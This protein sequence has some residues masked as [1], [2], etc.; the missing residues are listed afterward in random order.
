MNNL[1]PCP[2]CG[3][4]MAR[5]EL[6]GLCPDCMLKAGLGS[7]ADDTIAG[8]AA[9]FEPPAVSEIAN[10]F[11]NLDVIELLG[12]GGMGAVYKARQKNLDR[13]V[14]LKI[15]PPDIGSA[16]AF[17]ERF[18]REAK[19][20]AKLSH[21]NIVTIHDFGQAD[22]LFFLLMEFVDGVNLGQLLRAG[23]ISPR[24]A[25]AI[26]PQICDALQYAHDHGIVHR[27]IKPENILLD[28]QG[29]VKVADFGLAKLIGQADFTAQDGTSS[30]IG[31][32]QSAISNAVMGTP[33]YM[34][35]EQ[36]AHPSDVD[37][38]ADIYSLGVVFYQML[39]GELPK[40]DFAPPS[41]KV[42]L[43]VRLDEIVLRAMERRPELRYQQVSD[44]KTMCETIA[45]TSAHEDGRVPV[46]LS[47]S[48]AGQARQPPTA[49]WG[50]LIGQMIEMA[51]RR[52]EGGSTSVLTEQTLTGRKEIGRMAAFVFLLLYWAFAA[53]LI[54]SASCLPERVATHFGFEGQ[55]DGWMSR[56]FYLGFVGVF[57]AVMALIL[58]G[59]SALTQF[60]P[61]HY[62]NIPR[63][64]YWLVPERRAVTVGIIRSRLTGLLCLL[65][66]F[67]AGLHGLTLAAN[68][69]HPPQLPMGGLLLLV[70]I[71]LVAT[72][73][74]MALLLMRFAEAN[75]DHVG[76]LKAGAGATPAG[77]A[78][79]QKSAPR[80]NAGWAVGLTVVLHM[81]LP[82]LAVAGLLLVVPK[83]ADMFIELGA[84]LPRI[85]QVTLW[86]SRF[87]QS[88][89]FMLLPLFAVVD[90]L[91]SWLVQ[92][93]GGR[94][95]LVAWA[96]AGT[97]GL[98]AVVA[99]GV[100][101]MFLPLSQTIE[102]ISA[103]PQP[104]NR[105]PSA[106][107][108]PVMERVLPSGVPC[109]E[110]FFQFRSGK[111]FVAGN[112][113]GTSA[114]EAAY[115]EKKIEDAGG[116]DMSAGSGEQG[117]QI[118]GRGCIFTRDVQGLKWESMTAERVVDAM[119][120]VSF[121][122]GVLE[123]RKKDFPITYLFKTA[124]GEVG[125]MEVQGVVADERADNG[126][127]MKF[128]Y[129][130][131]QGTGT[132]TV[133][134]TASLAYGPET[135][136]LK[137]AVEVT[138]GEPFKL[139]IHVRN[140]SD[141]DISIE[142][143][144]YRQD[145]E[146]ILSD[147]LGRTV[148]VTKVTHAIKA[149][150]KAGSFGPGQVAVFESAG[151]SFQ[152]IDK[153]PA[154]A[155]YVAQAK[156]G[157]YTLRIR[158]RLPGTDVPFAAKTYA[159]QGELET[160]PVTIEVTDP[161]K[162]PV[163]P[164]ADSPSSAMLGPA[165]E[166]VVNDL[167]TTRESCALNFDTGQ[168]VPVPANIS[169]DTLTNPPA[170]AVATAWA[171]DSQA[172][173]I[174]FVI[175]GGDGVVRCGLLCPFLVVLRATSKDWDPDTADPRMLKEAFE[176]AMHSWNEIPQIA[177]VTT[178]GEFPANYLILD[179]R[180]HRRGVVQI[181]G[182]ADHPRG[183]KI[184]YR[185]VEG[186]P[187]IDAARTARLTS[188]TL[189]ILPA[190]WPDNES[191][192][193]S[194]KTPAGTEV[195]TLG[196]HAELLAT[197]FIGT[198]FW[199][200]V[201]NMNVSLSGLTQHTRVV[202]DRDTFA[203]STGYT[204]NNGLGE[205]TAEYAPGKVKL[206]AKN[207]LGQATTR[208]IPLSATAYDNEQVLFLIR[209]LPLAIGY[210]ASFPIFTVQ[211]GAVVECRVEVLGS[212]L[213]N[214]PAGEF[215]CFKTKL[216]IWAQGACVLQHMIYYSCDALR[217]VVY[218][219]AGAMTME[220][221]I[222]GASVQPSYSSPSLG[223][224]LKTPPGWQG[225][226]ALADATKKLLLQVNPP[227][228]LPINCYFFVKEAKGVELKAEMQESLS[229]SKGYFKGY[230]VREESY[231]ERIIH[232]LP[233]YSVVAD[234][235]GNL[236]SRMLAT[237]AGLPDKA[238]VEYRVYLMGKD[239]LGFVFRAEKARFDSSRPVFDKLV[240]ESLKIDASAP[241]ST[242]VEKE[243]EE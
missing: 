176:K 44:V 62:I 38:R 209:R 135:N 2:Q 222:T 35:P 166:R 157:R 158:L 4:P 207:V 185:L 20:L 212:E 47:A 241:D 138:P 114:E 161:A 141:R 175:S 218:Y 160:G 192:T 240:K 30:S 23:R 22:G 133:A 196:Y 81:A 122:E 134:A 230:A 155:G 139:L 125:I 86:A 5:K 91:I 197:D 90:V 105:V 190:P 69:T 170:Q 93:A 187:V 202:A 72:M 83:F 107:F 59:V 63:R 232:G 231:T 99:L 60:L 29:R 100:A 229:A 80:K 8:Q 121:I 112:G 233:S 173:A 13:F 74:W 188:G 97:L 199:E 193:L 96:V 169:L 178:T 51:A 205:F 204:Q 165:V 25:L 52:K 92:R 15:L 243:I 110:Q 154:S 168:F 148:T 19:A 242:G 64:D 111:V 127:G 76:A 116:V 213:K 66:L 146:C 150:I 55:A 109:R 151:L 239:I 58:A 123:P 73:I 174:A 79:P 9:R 225:F 45:A 201:G 7:L 182:V 82:I 140:V 3:H 89:G 16:P 211:G 238:M 224:H 6:M 17:A 228:N 223:I 95:A 136:G 39:T 36:V 177:D 237:Q 219:D 215:Q 21:P 226:A 183:V 70:I 171:R 53:A 54:A 48:A 208:E 77:C 42:V 216:E 167:L 214:V 84:Q 129:K 186:A 164:V 37:H 156:P 28:R 179:T 132:S 32:Q 180:T 1:T 102:R 56:S 14:A 124:R 40:G 191:F 67:F 108:G 41:K 106:V 34:A 162:Q 31:N 11:P 234:Y 101:S 18:V 94:K 220:L 98:G 113:P 26:V 50:W 85:T 149:G 46:P 118:V 49:G 43:D 130:L 189:A 119:K 221:M 71:F 200:I 128:R 65:T 194:I 172:D 68:R 87:V 137:A 27:D 159:W 195:G 75:A 163:A 227:T 235:Q 142:G 126:H 33:Q 144:L 104:Q 236:T 152:D 145:D 10:K 103:A 120:R 147:A 206:S 24:E 181:T 217:R 143:A 57:P 115:D 210:K 203:P 61:A 184:R 153:V 78:S 198:G 12:C 117:L 88:G 131:V